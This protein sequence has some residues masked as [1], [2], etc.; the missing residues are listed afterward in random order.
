MNEIKNTNLIPQGCIDKLNP[1]GKFCV[2][3]GMLPSS[4]KISMT[5]EEQLLWFCQYLENTVIPAVNTNAEAVAELQNLYNELKEYVDNYFTD[6]NVQ[7]EI[8]NKLDQMTESG[9]LTEIISAYLNTNSIL[10]FNSV[11]DMKSS[12]NLI[13]GSFVETYGFYKANDGGSAKYKIRNITNQDNI[14]EMFII[15]LNNPDLIAELQIDNSTI[16]ILQIGAKGD[17]EFD[18]TNVI[19]SAINFAYDNNFNVFVPNGIFKTTNTI[20]IETELTQNRPFPTIIG[21]KITSVSSNLVN[22]KMEGS[23]ILYA[24]NGGNAL[25]FVNNSKNN[26]FYGGLIKDINLINVNEFSQDNSKGLYL[27]GCIDY[28]I[29]NISCIGFNYGFYNNYGWSFDVY[30]LIAV[31]NQIGIFLDDNSN[32]CAFHGG[33]IHQNSINIK[34]ISGINILI[35]KV[36][37]E[38]TG[39]AMVVTSVDNISTPS[40]INVE[41]CYLEANPRGFLIGKDQANITASSSVDVLNFKNI[42]VSG[43]NLNVLFEIDNAKHI[44]IDSILW[45]NSKPLYISTENTYDVKLFNYGS[46]FYNNFNNRY[47]V[48]R[49]TLLKNNRNLIPNGFGLFPCIKNLTSNSGYKVEFDTSTFPR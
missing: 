43:S 18:N 12:T 14:D 41:N 31:R 4:Y 7:K 49:K 9:E 29:Y 39:V 47:A 45:S 44:T 15:S 3:I 19:Q 32:A 42:S 13:N 17:N 22:K 16:N 6:L 36:T 20:G 11:N 34:I 28:R 40:N 23:I 30:G 48:E 1:F 21:E 26:F 27:Q 33:Q 8:N 37:I 10:A 38:G 46:K 2:T 35:E 25:Q 5:Y 24:G